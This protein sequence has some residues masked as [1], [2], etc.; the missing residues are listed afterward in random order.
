MITLRKNSPG[1]LGTW[2]S[3]FLIGKDVV[4]GLFTVGKIRS[5]Q[6]S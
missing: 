3:A 4:S 5:F 6:Y 1:L 2:F